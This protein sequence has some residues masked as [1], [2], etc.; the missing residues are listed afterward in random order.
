MWILCRFWPTISVFAFESQHFPVFMS[1]NC[2]H[3][4]SFSSTFWC[5]ALQVSQFYS[6]WVEKWS[7]FLV[8]RSRFWF[9][10]QNV[11]SFLFLKCQ[12]FGLKVKNCRN[13]SFW[14]Q[15]FDVWFCRSKLT[16]SGLKMEFFLVK[17]SKFVEILGFMSK[18]SSFLFLK[19]Q[20]FS[21]FK[22]NILIFGFEGKKKCQNWSKFQFFK[23]EMCQNFDFW[24]LKVK[25]FQFL[26]EKKVS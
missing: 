9:L 1:T 23:V 25:I 22:V 16:V 7:I 18:F 2:R 3:F 21:I 14:G 24:F 10:C 6:F 19:C 8:K 13:F 15:N 26:G 12:N 17:R 5:L 20:N 11:S 4:R